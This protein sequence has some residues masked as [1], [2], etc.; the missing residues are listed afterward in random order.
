[1][2][3]ANRIL[4]TKFFL[5]QPT[6]DFVERKSLASKFDKIKAMPI[7][8]VSASTGYGKSTV[9]S[10]FLKNQ[11]EDHVWLSLSEKEN[12]FQQFILYFI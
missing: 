8:L 2:P 1:M 3:I 12:E 7:M 11:E 6:S 10:T 9:I 4:K 5:P